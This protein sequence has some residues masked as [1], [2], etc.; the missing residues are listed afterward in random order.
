MVGDPGAAIVTNL[1][2]FGG[3]NFDTATALNL[4]NTAATQPGIRSRNC[5]TRPGLAEYLARGYIPTS[6]TNVWG[7]PATTLEYAVADAAIAHF[8][9]ALGDSA[10]RDLFLGHAQA[11]KQLFS[12]ATG[13]LEP[14]DANG[15]FINGAPT[16]PTYYVEGDAAQY[17]W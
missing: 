8:A 1:Y 6:D 10:K 5:E 3:T 16:D 15:G 7:Q 13:Y 2:A 14:R 11:W 12:N 17:T 9:D 4:M